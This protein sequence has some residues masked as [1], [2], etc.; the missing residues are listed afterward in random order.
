MTEFEGFGVKVQD[1]FRGLESDNSKE[2]FTAHRDFFEESIRDQMK[3]LLAELSK[4]FG[5]EIKMFRQTETSG[6]RA[7][8]R[9]TRLTRTASCPAPLSRRRVCGLAGAEPR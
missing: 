3:A 6:S 7:T 9:R 8:S 5:G 4:E 1:W 2:Y